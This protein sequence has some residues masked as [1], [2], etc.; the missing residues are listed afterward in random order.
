KSNDFLHIFSLSPIYKTTSF[1][2]KNLFT[3]DSTCS[4]VLTA[5]STLFSTKD[6]TDCTVSFIWSITS[7][8]FAIQSVTLS[9]N[10]TRWSFA[11]VRVSLLSKLTILPLAASAIISVNS[12]LFPIFLSPYHLFYVLF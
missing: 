10:Y 8:G 12:F 2:F 4:N 3:V 1:Y 6:D 7:D 5:P 11:Y 9:F